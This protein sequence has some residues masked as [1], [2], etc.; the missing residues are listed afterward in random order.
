MIERKDAF[1]SVT[2]LTFK[3]QTLS[4][5]LYRSRDVH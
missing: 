4:L 2:V 3:V 5:K 1:I